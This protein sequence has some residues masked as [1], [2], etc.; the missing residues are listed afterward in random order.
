MG[1]FEL[2][3]I[4]QFYMVLSFLCYNFREY[5]AMK[6][7]SEKA[8]G[9]ELQV[10]GAEAFAREEGDTIELRRTVKYHHN[11][12]SFE[13]TA[14]VVYSKDKLGIESG[15][16][17]SV[18]NVNFKNYPRTYKTRFKIYFPESFEGKKDLV[19]NVHK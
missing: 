14:S 8:A 10:D 11:N 16:I 2:S 9:H 5:V 7:I 17:Y 3:A 13:L 6:D 12:V 15:P 1:N 4:N 18:S 19:Y